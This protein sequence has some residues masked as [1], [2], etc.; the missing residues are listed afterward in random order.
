MRDSNLNTNNALDTEF[1]PVEL[2]RV[3]EEEFEMWDIE[4]CIASAD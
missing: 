3:I 1:T 4:P 2:D